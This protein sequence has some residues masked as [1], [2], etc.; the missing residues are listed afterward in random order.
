MSKENQIDRDGCYICDGGNADVLE[1]HHIVPRRFGGSD[2][3]ENLVDLCPS[4]HEV[5]ERLY[6]KR[7][8][9]VLGVSKEEKDFDYL[10][11]EAE[12]CAHA[13]Q[14]FT[15][16]QDVFCCDEH[17]TCDYDRCD[18]TPVSVVDSR[19]RDDVTGLLCESHVVCSH[20]GCASTDTRIVEVEKITST[21]CEPYCDY[22]G[23]EKEV[24]ADE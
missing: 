11:V 8:Y 24:E 13:T 23:F 19:N 7:F 5:L 10:C 1:R 2:S 6:D 21:E 18:K 16:V 20:R 17:A 4:C 15:G 9:D 14:K 12:C 22:H 3:A